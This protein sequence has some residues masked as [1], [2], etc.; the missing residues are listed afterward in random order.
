MGKDYCRSL[1][2]RSGPGDKAGFSVRTSSKSVAK[3]TFFLKRESREN[4][5]RNFKFTEQ[6]SSLSGD[7]TKPE[8]HRFSEQH[9]FSPKERGWSKTSHKF[10]GIE[11]IS[12]IRTFQD[13]GHPS[14]ERSSFEERLSSQTGSQR[15]LSDYPSVQRTSKVSTL[16]LARQTDG[17]CLS[18]IRNQYSTSILQQNPKNPNCTPQKNGD[19]FNHISRRYLDNE[20]IA[21]RRDF[22]SES[23][24]DF[25]DTVRVSDKCREVDIGTLSGDRFSR[26]YSEYDKDDTFTSKRQSTENSGNLSKISCKRKSLSPRISSFDWSTDSCKSSHIPCST[27]LQK[28]A[29]FENKGSSFR[30]S[31]RSLHNSRSG[32]QVRT[33]MVGCKIRRLEWE[34]NPEP[35]TFYDNSVR[36]ESPRMG[37][38]KS[39]CEDRWGLV[40]GGNMSPYQYTRI[41]SSTFCCESVHKECT[42]QTCVTTNGQQSSNIIYKQNGEYSVKTNDS[43]KS[44]SLGLVPSETDSVDS[45]IHPVQ[46]KLYRGLGIEEHDGQEQLETQSVNVQESDDCVRSLQHRPI[47]RQVQCPTQSLFQLE[48]RSPGCSSECISAGLEQSQG[49]CF[50]PFLLNSSMSSQDN[51]RTGGNSVDHANMAIAG[52]VSHVTPNVNPKSSVN[53]N[54]ALSSPISSEGESPISPERNIVSSRVESLRVSYKTKGFSKQVE[55]LLLGSWRKGTTSAYNSA[56][57][58]WSSWCDK[59]QINP[60]SAPLASVL[61]FLA[62][63]HHKNYEYRTINVHR[64]AISSVLPFIDGVPVGQSPVVK[65]LLKGILLKNPPQPRY[66][67]SW[68][69]DIVLRFLLSLPCNKKMELKILSKKLAILLALAAPKRVSEIARLD[70]RFMAKRNDSISFDLPG[71]S[72]TQT[73]PTARSVKYQKFNKKKLCPVSCILDYE[74]KTEHMRPNQEC[75]PDPLLRATRKPHK[76]VTSQTISHWIKDVMNEAGIDTKKF[77]PHSCR[78]SATSKAMQTGVNLDEILNMADWSNAKTFKKFYFRPVGT[79]SFAKNVLELVNIF[80]RL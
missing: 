46:G 12:S 70:R 73:D 67:F 24:H 20:S 8:R 15:C 26:L 38:C 39:R 63:M 78:M 31:L 71:L 64:S 16:S 61:D 68:D 42:K 6:K 17:I 48:T 74:A 76:G 62:W 56:W 10:K 66:Q 54:G 65:Q 37:G 57:Q 3:S 51:E 14:F 41:K 22:R 36:L 9:I 7:F 52:L 32:V 72:K 55:E 53:P 5:H 25:V 69:L 4:K 80:F 29:V 1:D 13:G 43:I 21:I 79:E 23:S 27:S 75:E 44:T 18:S 49:V 50:S 47:C 34:N 40:E 30:G 58:K 19:P 60:F 59:R 28:S 2:F 35:R 77:K 33:S 45:R 11:C